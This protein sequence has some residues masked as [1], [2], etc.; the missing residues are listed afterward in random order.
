MKHGLVLSGGGFKAAFQVGAVELLIEKGIE[1]SAISGV[2]AGALNGSQL[3]QDKLQ[4]LI[5]FWI[6][7]GQTEGNFITDPYLAK[8]NKYGLTPVQDKIYEVAFKGI[9]KLNI[10]QAILSKNKRKSLVSKVID[11]LSK[12]GGIL[13]NRP[14]HNILLENTKLEDFK[15]PF[16][17]SVVS[18]Y[19]GR[20]Y[21]LSQKDFNFS[22]EMATAL[23]ASSTMPVV[24][25]PVLT[26][27][28]KKL[29]IINAVDGGLRM[30]NP[31][32]QVFNYVQDDTEDWT[33]WI[34]NCNTSE[35]PYREVYSSLIQTS[36]HA[37]EIILNEVMNNDIEFSFKVNEWADKINK[38]KVILKIIEP[39]TTLGN[40]LQA[41]PEII[42]T[43]MQRGRLKALK[44]FS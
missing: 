22:S 29:T 36:G 31:L 5:E 13:D 8:L 39:A 10:T 17:F 28:T 6:Q 1:F 19:S 9:T 3:A 25:D 38:K 18:L 20:L 4:N 11:N 34:I 15:V 40:T 12:V 42:K 27:N 26:V 32:S 35:L 7:V 2:S 44:H 16:F 23:L 30:I 24:W 41:N 37:L 21:E 14:L 33:I 43:R